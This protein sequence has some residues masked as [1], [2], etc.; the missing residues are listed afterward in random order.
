MSSREQSVT[1]LRR[2]KRKMVDNLTALGF[3][4][5]SY[6]MRASEFPKYI[7]WAGGLL[8]LTVAVNRVLEDGSI[9]H[10]YFTEAEWKSLSD[11]NKS[12]FFR[13]GIRVRAE[14][15]SFVI[16]LEHLG[17][18]KWCEESVGVPDLPTYSS[19]AV[20]DSKYVGLLNEVSSRQYT[21]L[22]SGISATTPASDAVLAF[23]AD[24]PQDDSEWGLP[25]PIHLL[26]IYRYFNE[27]NAFIT[28]ISNAG[29]KIGETVAWTCI[30]SST[31]VAW[32]FNLSDA[33]INAATKTTVA[34]VI[35]ICVEPSK[36]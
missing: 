7:K 16:P 12:L 11:E 31:T 32:Q 27:I 19:S 23:R 24:E 18:C 30:P 33:T 5:L 8:D 17:D 10:R 26:L 9:E 25:C 29:N 3:T 35:P 1:L 6:N 36:L 13:R 22:I 28:S 20:P 4:G 21:E 14:K 34:R 2:N 15:Q